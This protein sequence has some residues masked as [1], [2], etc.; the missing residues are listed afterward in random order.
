M[1]ENTNI[2]FVPVEDEKGSLGRADKRWD[3]V[4]TTKLYADEVIAD[5]SPLLDTRIQLEELQTKIIQLEERVEVLH[6]VDPHQP[7]IEALI[8]ELEAVKD[9]VIEAQGRVDQYT[10]DKHEN[11]A[12]IAAITD[13]INKHDS[14]IAELEQRLHQYL[15]ASAIIAEL[16]TQIALGNDEKDA[17]YGEVINAG[18]TTK[19][20]LPLASGLP[21]NICNWQVR[22]DFEASPGIIFKKADGELLKDELCGDSGLLGTLGDEWVLAN[23]NKDQS[24]KVIE[25]SLAQKH[26]L[27]AER[28]QIRSEQKYFE[29]SKYTLDQI[30][31]AVNFDEDKLAQFTFNAHVE[32]PGLQKKYSIM[33][34]YK[35]NGM[36]QTLELIEGRTEQMRK[37][38]VDVLIAKIT[39]YQ[40]LIDLILI[41]QDGDGY[42]KLEEYD[43]D[44]L[45]NNQK[46]QVAESEKQQYD[47]EITDLE[48]EMASIAAVRY[49]N[50]SH[51]L[52]WTARVRSREAE[53]T[54]PHPGHS[55]WPLG[56]VAFIDALQA[57]AGALTIRDMFE[58][59]ISDRQAAARDA[60]TDLDSRQKE[61]PGIEVL[62]SDAKTDL[63]G[64]NEAYT[65][66]LS[67][68][69]AAIEAL[70]MGPVE[71][72]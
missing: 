48:T 25:D 31:E 12:E 14:K 59:E 23:E 6:R 20:N 68:M 1:P 55:V 47:K 61:L 54:E 72:S 32:Y 13:A 26:Q 8:V 67:S 19:V 30:L 58:I 16:D 64:R 71:T 39:M 60:E 37:D 29:A 15:E 57:Q 17:K 24:V 5:G 52:Y 62:L 66:A 27:E 65:I 46:L 42:N 40:D 41:D 21:H 4:Y 44:I 63:A 33:P 22:E 38:E 51:V 45:E 3:G 18:N 36:T 2:N 10:K 11:L 70:F 56:Y 53:K 9:L 35:F 34:N 28:N 50:I 69:K 49:V 43:R 7:I